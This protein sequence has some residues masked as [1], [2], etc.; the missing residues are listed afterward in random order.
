MVDK[1]QNKLP[2]WRRIKLVTY[3]GDKDTVLS[4][5]CEDYGN[6]ALTKISLTCSSIPLLL[7]TL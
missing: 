5:C 3:V 2:S 6:T 1:V 4:L 7:S